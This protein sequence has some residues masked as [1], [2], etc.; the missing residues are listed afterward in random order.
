MTIYRGRWADPAS[1][2]AFSKLTLLT[3]LNHLGVNFCKPF[4]VRNMSDTRYPIAV[5]CTY[6]RRGANSAQG[7]SKEWKRLRPFELSPSR[8]L[9]RLPCTSEPAWTV[10]LQPA[11]TLAG[12]ICGDR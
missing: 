1:A 4:Q 10:R 5:C 12:L 7:N 6:L 9:C 8:R 11:A 2:P 3:P